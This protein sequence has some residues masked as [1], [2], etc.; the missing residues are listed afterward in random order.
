M[1]IRLQIYEITDNFPTQRV[2]ILIIWP[3]FLGDFME[4]L[5]LCQVKGEKVGCEA[6]K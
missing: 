6:G 5:L 3:L 4:I 1:S 2:I